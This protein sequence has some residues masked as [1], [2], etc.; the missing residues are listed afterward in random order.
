[1]RVIGLVIVLAVT[2]APFLAEAQQAARIPSVALISVALAPERIDA[3]R[4][5][6]RQLGY[7]DRQN[8]VIEVRDAAGKTDRLPGL[9]A[10]LV[11]LKVDAI[12]AAGSDAIRA[13]QQATRTIPIVI[14]VGGGDLVARGL[15]RSLA[16]PGGNITGLRTNSEVIMTKRLQLI[17]EAVPKVTRV[18]VLWRR[19]NPTHQPTLKEIEGAAASIGMQLQPAE[20]RQ[21]AELDAAFA[22]MTK[23]RA[24]AVLVL[25]DLLFES[26]R[27]Q[28]ADLAARG[29][30]PA[31]CTAKVFVQA[32]GLMSY[33]TDQNDLY[34]RAATYVDKILKGASPGDLPVELPTK[35]ELVLNLKTAKRLGIKIP[36]T[37]ILQADQVIE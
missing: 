19:D 36:Q 32:G 20:A 21:A 16:R 35:Y 26:Q 10:D 34:R 37:V 8:V 6:L 22:A 2:I 28:I 24:G 3:F 25:G 33:A 14:A 27:G 4:D 31:M 29:K 1:M 17:K 13:A 9:V 15:V 5:G 7:A 12:V 11:Q 18:A 23:G 30:L